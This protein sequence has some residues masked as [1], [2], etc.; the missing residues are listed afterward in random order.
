MPPVTCL[1][2]ARDQVAVGQVAV[3]VGEDVRRLSIRE[4]VAVG[5]A[6]AA[7]RR[8]LQ[9]LEERPS[10]I[11]GAKETSW[12]LDREG[13]RAQCQQEGDGGL[14]DGVGAGEVA[15]RSGLRDAVLR[16]RDRQPNE[17]EF[18]RRESPLWFPP[19]HVLYGVPIRAGPGKNFPRSV[20][21][22]IGL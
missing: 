15:K 12:V 20:Q 9:E 22:C 17:I 19:A 13:L 21:E 14:A 10:E 8:W 6:P 18:A 16:A 7:V 1:V 2:F 5:L 4:R 3:D 11:S